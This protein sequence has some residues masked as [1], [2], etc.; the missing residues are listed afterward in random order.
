MAS[1]IVPSHSN[2]DIVVFGLHA[3]LIIKVGV[4]VEDEL[5]PALVDI[6]PI[7]DLRKSLERVK[8]TVR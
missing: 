6:V 8:H 7:G 5:I 1:V 2:V 4:A 3:I